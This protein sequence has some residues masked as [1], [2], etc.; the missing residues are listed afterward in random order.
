MAEQQ[1]ILV[2]RICPLLAQSG[3]LAAEFQMGGHLRQ[4]S[5]ERREGR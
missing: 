4:P 1:L 3:H 2:Q 5:S